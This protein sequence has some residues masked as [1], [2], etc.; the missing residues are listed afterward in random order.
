MLRE[1]IQEIV[2]LGQAGQ[3]AEVV[4]VP[5]MRRKSLLAFRGNLNEYPHD[6][7]K[8]S[9]TVHDLASLAAAANE[10]GAEGDVSAWVAFERVVAILQDTDESDREDRVTLALHPSPLFGLLERLAGLHEPKKLVTALRTQFATAFITPD[11]ADL[12]IGNLKFHTEDDETHAHKKGADA[13]GR[14]VR[15]EVT[16]ADAVPDF[17]EFAFQ[18]YPDLVDEVSTEVEV[19][20]SLVVDPTERKVSFHPVPG[21]IDAARTAATTALAS[22]IKEDFGRVFCGT[23]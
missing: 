12:A 9:H 6:P 15:A 4:S 23:P 14:S 13:M 3:S 8:R 22:R 10:Y 1:A 2:E 17:V 18:A 5:G 11:D 7:P 21:A 16:N 20:C 19:R